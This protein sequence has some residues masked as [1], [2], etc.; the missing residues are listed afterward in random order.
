[1]P[2]AAP[3]IRYL[4]TLVGPYPEARE[5]YKA[6]S[7]IHHLD[8]LSCP[9]ILFQG[10]EDKVVPPSQAEAMYNAVKAKGLPVAYV[11]FKGEQHG[12]RQADNIRA[13]VDG[14]FAF[15]CTIFGIHPADADSLPKLHIENWPK[16]QL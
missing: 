7:P 9:I 1:M 8:G 15:F 5:V 6:R 16:P 3:F 10:D 2:C 11:L 14:E 12:F 13:N 4:D